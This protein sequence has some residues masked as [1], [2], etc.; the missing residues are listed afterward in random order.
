MKKV[1]IILLI[2]N[3]M[4]LFSSEDLS[5]VIFEKTAFTGSF[6]VAK[7]EKEQFENLVIVHNSKTDIYKVLLG[8]YEGD[9][10]VQLK[11]LIPFDPNSPIRGK[12]VPGEYKNAE[13]LGEMG[14]YSIKYLS[15][16]IDESSYSLKVI[17][18]KSIM[19]PES[20]FPDPTGEVLVTERE[21]IFT[22]SSF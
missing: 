15:T 22:L 5:K 9:N 11:E 21:Y 6:D 1:L 13:S 7:A 18:K 3:G 16:Y 17:E 14:F 20:D 19:N 2:I 10:F 8:Y 12:K 4:M